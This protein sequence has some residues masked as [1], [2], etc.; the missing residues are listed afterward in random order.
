MNSIETLKKLIQDSPLSLEAKKKWEK[1]I[2]FFNDQQIKALISLLKEN[3]N[4]IL[5]LDRNLEEKL[6]IIRAKDKEAWRKLMEEE[7]KK[8]SDF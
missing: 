6:K 3:P 5:E 4:E 2:C 1:G 7:R 8:I